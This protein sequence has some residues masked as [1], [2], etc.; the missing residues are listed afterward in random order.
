MAAQN[1]PD[2]S[3]QSPEPSHRRSNVPHLPDDLI[4]A[5]ISFLPPKEVS[6]LAVLS[7]RFRYSW[8]FCRDLCFD[9][10]FAMNMS[11]D[12]YKDIVNKFFFYNVNSRADTFKLYFD[13]AGDTCL[14]CY[15]IH[16]AVTL[17]VHEFELDFTPSAKKYML[18]YE[19]V[20]V[21]TIKVMRLVNCELHL[22]FVSNGLRHLR[23]LTFERVRARPVAMQ[24]IFLNCVS[25]RSLQ[26]IQCNNVYN[27]KIAALELK[28]FQNLV[29]K[30]CSDVDSVSI[31]APALRSFHY[32][33]KICDFKFYS[34]LPKLN[35][36]VLE[37]AHPRGFHLLSNREHVVIS[38]A[39]VKV[40][41]VTSTFLE[42]LSARFEDNEYKGM[43]FCM[44]RLEEFHLIVAPESYLLPS[45]IA[46]F[47]KKCP[48]IERVFIDL[49]NNA[50]GTSVYWESYG[51]KYLNE[52]QTVFPHLKCVK[53]KGFTLNELPVTMARFF[54]K[55][56]VH[57]HYLVLVKAKRHYVPETF[58]PDCLRWGTTS[59]AQIQIYDPQG[60]TSNIIPQYL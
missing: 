6:R 9:R 54:L 60:D 52:W 11:R 51:R 18:S 25:L 20:D 19:L 30:N 21:K 23:E 12:E 33:G 36:V 42:G 58:V 39:F 40:L 45:D 38:L 49:G 56:A 16:R 10:E 32:H 53:I 28:D 47:L 34:D 37:I 22:P 27:L 31:K 2:M 48:R 8:H 50:F 35:D 43:E 57:L 13:A 5:I 7:K 4:E 29:V 17:G 1:H 44:P 46:S 26:L 3:L 14:V 59:N 15:W 55:T 24:A 41:T